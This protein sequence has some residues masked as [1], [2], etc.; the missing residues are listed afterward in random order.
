MILFQIL[1]TLFALFAISSVI[2]R[3]R[4]N[5][6]G[7]KG[8]IFWVLFWIASIIAV[9]SPDTITVLANTFG[10]GRGTD[11]VLYISIIVIFYL[12]FKLHL[13]V[14]MISRN[15]TKVIRK[16]AIENCEKKDSLS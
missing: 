11:F 15:I 14:E 6:F 7:A 12:I 9:L 16:E 13:K 2:K 3:K 5:Q 8:A 1:F 10:I 4:S